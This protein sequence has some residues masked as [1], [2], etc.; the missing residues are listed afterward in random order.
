MKVAHLTWSMSRRAGGMLDGTRRLTQELC[1]QGVDID[2]FSSRDSFSDA[3]LPLWNG[4][5]VKLLDVVGP[6]SFGFVPRLAQELREGAFDLVHTHGLWTYV[7][8]VRK[9][10]NEGRPIPCMT[11]PQGMLDPWALQ[12][13][14]WKKK[15]AGWAYERKRLQLSACL[16]AVCLAEADAMRTYGLSNPICVIP[17]GV[18]LP[19]GEWKPASPP[20]DADLVGGRNVLLFLS[21]LH[22]KKGLAN[23]LHAWATLQA[24]KKTTS[25]WC[26]AI[27]GW[28]QGGHEAE[29]QRIIQ[30]RSIG[31]DVSLIGPI[32][33][34][35]REAAYL[36]ADAFVLPSQG[37]GLPI[38]VLEAWAHS[39]P[40]LM[41]VGCNLSE[42]NQ[43][44]A[45]IE[46]EPSVKSLAEGL[47][48]FF[49]LS[50]EERLAMGMKGF[51]LVRE[52]FTWPRIAAEM[53]TVYDWVLGAGDRPDCVLLN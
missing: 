5:S 18:D 46:V 32:Y 19:E 21:R 35:A 28:D 34:E 7:S 47:R 37:E 26:L 12:N 3:D 38:A 16:H 27:A 49:A 42:G 43:T 1:S 6:Q 23:L 44:G 39:L 29:L 10:A 8:A 20:W 51:A 45:A 24:D 13:S 11:S 4:S 50:D 17:N 41:T 25:G 53:K 31:E 52:R 9:A 30:E 22:P 14:H 33:G 15:L 48:N 2:V 36:S 40:V